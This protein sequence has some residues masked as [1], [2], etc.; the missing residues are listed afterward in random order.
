MTLHCVGLLFCKSAASLG[1]GGLDCSVTWFPVG[2]GHAV[3]AAPYWKTG[4]TGL[5]CLTCLTC[6][7]EDASGFIY[8]AL[9]DRATGKPAS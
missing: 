6:L 7:S 1:S 5:W 4:S 2:P 8:N 9:M 3:L